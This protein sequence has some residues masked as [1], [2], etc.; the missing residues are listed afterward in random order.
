MPLSIG[1]LCDSV[2][3]EPVESE[4]TFAGGALVLPESG[5][6]KPSEVFICAAGP[7]RYDDEGEKRIPGT[8]T[9]DSTTRILMFTKSN[10]T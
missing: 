1:P 6:D 3:V 4:E 7:G 2:L 5:K 8:T 10:K 9:A